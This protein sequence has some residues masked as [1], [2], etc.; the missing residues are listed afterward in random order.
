MAEVSVREFGRRVGRSHVWVLGQIKAGKIPRNENGKIPLDEGLAAFEEY[1]R[2]KGIEDEL[3]PG[4]DLN[5]E[6]LKAKTRKEARLADIKTIEAQKLKGEVVDVAEVKADAR[7]VAMKMRAFCLSGPTRY[8]GLLEGRSQR[9]A[10]AV[11]QNLFS[12]LLTAIHDGR[13]ME[14]DEWESGLTPSSS[15]ASRS[16]E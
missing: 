6:L 9:E 16:Q 11:L 13:F 5:E 7:A 4:A 10:E 15:S 12:E 2:E 14:K 3:P 8:A 1:K